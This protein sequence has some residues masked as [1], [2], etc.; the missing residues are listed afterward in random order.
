[1]SERKIPS[2]VSL[3]FWAGFGVVAGFI[4]LQFF[5]VFFGW[6]AAVVL[7]PLASFFANHDV[8]YGLTQN[9]L[10]AIYSA[11]A[12]GG[13]DLIFLW[14]MY[15]LL[16]KVTPQQHSRWELIGLTLRCGWKLWTLQ[17]VLGIVICLSL[18]WNDNFS[19]IWLVPPFMTSSISNALYMMVWEI[20]LVLFGLGFAI[21]P[22][23]RQALANGASLLLSY[24]WVWFI[25]ATVGFGLTLLPSIF[26]SETV[27]AF[28]LLL[29][30]IINHIVLFVVALIFFF[31]QPDLFEEDKPATSV[32]AVEDSQPEIPQI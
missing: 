26:I 23:R 31:N 11:L 25:V 32:A 12:V 16:N 3:F 15:V 18:F 7:G 4:L 28:V 17:V 1:M 13:L 20:S 10:L 19:S 27:R 24:W 6:L 5:P 2:W 9:A 30:G 21:N 14:I 8:I 29:W 22:S